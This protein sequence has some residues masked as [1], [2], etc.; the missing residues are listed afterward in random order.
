MATLIM[1]YMYTYHFP[2]MTA[3]NT[4]TFDLGT[5]L[6]Y[7]CAFGA[8]FHNSATNTYEAKKTF[9][10]GAD[11]NWSPV[12]ASPTPLEPCVCT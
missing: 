5:V 1:K 3:G 7:E 4:K 9:T 6:E 11:G 12:P 10:C 8:E 2:G